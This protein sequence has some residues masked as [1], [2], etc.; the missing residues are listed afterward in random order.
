MKLERIFISYFVTLLLAVAPAVANQQQNKLEVV[1]DQKSGLISIHAENVSLTEVMWEVSAVTGLIVKTSNRDILNEYV[2]IDLK[3]IS[4]KQVVDRLLYGVNSVFF[5]ASK[6]TQTATPR[7]TKVML[8]SRKEGLPA[9]TISNQS[10]ESGRGIDIRSPAKETLL[11]TILATEL[12][13]SILEDNSFATERILQQLLETGTPEEIKTA[14]EAMGNLMLD[15]SFYGQASNG[16]AFYEALSALKKL[17]LKGTE[18][19]LT[20]LLQT[21]EEPWVQSLAAENL[22]GVGQA[23]SVPPLLT[24]SPVITPTYEIPPPAVWRK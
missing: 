23:E 2:T 20:K 14:V 9:A 12:G 17:D 15:P 4:L 24:P 10:Q 6:P 8:L 3:N 1:Q 5:Y 16:H 22:G 18:N 7:L 11:K 21:S 13:R 19:Y